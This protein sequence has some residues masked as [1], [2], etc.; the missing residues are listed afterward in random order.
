M[1]LRT[2]EVMGACPVSCAPAHRELSVTGVLSNGPSILGQASGDRATVWW[3]HH[4][5]A[6][7]VAAGEVT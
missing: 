2:S 6:V 5:P 7:L 3:C 1:S 4:R